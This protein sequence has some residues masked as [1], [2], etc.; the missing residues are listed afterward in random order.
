MQACFFGKSFVFRIIILSWIWGATWR[1]KREGKGGKRGEGRE[2]KEKTGKPR[3]GRE[4][5]RSKYLVTALHC[6]VWRDV[7][8]WYHS[9]HR[10]S[11]TTAVIDVDLW[12]VC[13]RL[14]GDQ[15]L[16]SAKCSRFAGGWQSADA[17]SSSRSV[18]PT[19]AGQRPVTSVVVPGVT[20]PLYRGAWP[21]HAIPVSP[22]A[23][24]P[25]AGSTPPPL[26]T[27]F[28][29]MLGPPTLS[30][31]IGDLGSCLMSVDAVSRRAKELGTETDG[32]GGGGTDDNTGGTDGSSGAVLPFTEL[33]QTEW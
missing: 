27:R 22:N 20:R 12:T 17:S 33:Q 6:S 30:G 9:S 26:L 5:A 24:P 3:K 15:P 7:I 2:G 10:W 1:L 16:L 4:P 11:T 14:Y 29:P 25:A 23:L 21:L 32:G 28:S 19:A 8:S 18:G 13:Q 31:G